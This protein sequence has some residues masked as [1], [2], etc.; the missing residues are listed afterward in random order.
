MDRP[1]PCWPAPDPAAAAR[2][3]R[4]VRR[5]RTRIEAAGGSIPFSAYMQAILHEPGLG[6][7]AANVAGFGPSGDFV[8]APELSAVFAH[9]LGGEIAS[10]LDALGSPRTVL[11]LGAGS[12][13][14]AEGLLRRLGPC[15]ERPLV[16]RILEPSPRLR[17]VQ[18]E[19]L[20]SVAAEVGAK[21]EWLTALPAE[22]F[23]GVVVANEVADALP[24]ERFQIGAD[25]PLPLHVTYHEGRLRSRPGPPDP[26]LRTWLAGLERRLGHAL[27]EGYR[28]EVC[29]WLP[30]WLAALGAVLRRGAVLLFDYGY[31]E[32]EYYHPERRDGTLLCHYRHRA[33][34]D[35]YFLPGLQDV[36]AS[37]DFSA[38]A[39]AAEAAGLAVAGYT[40]QAWF[41]IGRDLEG[42]MR[43]RVG[44]GREY[45]AL[46][47]AV[48]TLT[49]PGAMGERVKA[50]ALAKELRPPLEGFGARDLRGRL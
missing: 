35:P 25:G 40:T 17:A 14:L 36:S 26:A 38:V 28:S 49:M 41:L 20:R 33:H 21:V 2:S 19:R 16:Y 42:Y 3:E 18:T 31:E 13:A 10:V 1:D 4:L 39:R 23:D 43:E 46:A 50:I 11:E 8:T 30:G 27:G 22:P 45:Y 34:A 7:Y 15:F 5:L 44:G 24:V 12:G 32:R 47:S 37:V 48:R 9:C 6:Y 29:R